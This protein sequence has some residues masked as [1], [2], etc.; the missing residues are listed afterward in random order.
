[1]T[2]SSWLGT[3]AML[4][5]VFVLCTFIGASGMRAPLKRMLVAGLVM[6]VVGALLMLAIIYSVYGGIADAMRYFREGLALT[7]RMFAGD[8]ASFTDERHWLGGRWWGTQF[9]VFT[10]SFVTAVLGPSRPGAFIFYALLAFVGLCLFTVAFV[11]AHPHAR[12]ERYLAWLAFFPSLWL[13][14]SVIGKEALI[15][16]GLGLVVFGYV[17]VGRIAWIPLGLG[18]VLIGAIRPQ[19]AAVVAFTVFLAQWLGRD[20]RWTPVRVV[21]T[22]AILAVGLG[23]LSYGLGMLGVSETGVAGVSE[24]LADEAGGMDVGNTSV[25]ATGVGL[26]GVPL[27]LV[28]VLFRPF[29]WEADSLMTF[30]SGVELWGMWALFLVRRRDVV[31]ALRQ[32]RSSRLLAMGIPFALV[33]AAIFGMLV[34]NLGII[35]RQR[36]FIFPFLLALLEAAPAPAGTGA[37]RPARGAV[38]RVPAPRVPALRQEGTAG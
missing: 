20:Q 6:R 38:R 11:R 28:N 9:V 14:P 3:A 1:M 29:P 4:G 37:R 33:Y 30:A 23:T 15:L 8:F 22:L 36:I 31:R 5:L 21:Q 32:W 24:Y 34:V 25:E 26:A 12:P 17:R 19:V 2:S 7:E 18:L 27:A 10:S 16:L 35:A 13:W